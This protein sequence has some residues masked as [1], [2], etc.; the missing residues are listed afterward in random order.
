G[1]KLVTKFALLF[2]VLRKRRGGGS[3]AVDA[4][5]LDTLNDVLTTASSLLGIGLVRAG[6]PL[7]DALLALP[8]ALY[9]G[10]NG[11]LL[12]RESMRYLMGEAP[13]ATVLGEL[14]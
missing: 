12:A 5:R 14:R 1:T 7:A 2:V 11:Y 9:I 10:R 3:Q 4:T 8:V 6:W 13:P